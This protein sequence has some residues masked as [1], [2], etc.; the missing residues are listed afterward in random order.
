LGE[1]IPDIDKYLLPIIALIVFVS[2]LP[3]LLEMRKNRR[4]SA[5]AGDGGESQG[6]SGA[7]LPRTHDEA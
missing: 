4:S 6:E 1:S 5:S 2:V 3:M 7:S